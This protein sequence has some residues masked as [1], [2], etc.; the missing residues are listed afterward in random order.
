MRGITVTRVCEHFLW[1]WSWGQKVAQFRALSTGQNE[2][3][4]TVMD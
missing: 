1:V 2:V 4:P 3:I